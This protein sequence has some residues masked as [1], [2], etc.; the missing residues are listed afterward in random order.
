M[1]SFLKALLNTLNITDEKY[2]IKQLEVLN[3]LIK[4]QLLIITI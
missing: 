3:F 1:N 2:T 4:I